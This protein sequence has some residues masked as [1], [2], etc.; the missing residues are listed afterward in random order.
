MVHSFNTYLSWGSNMPDTVLSK[1]WKWFINQLSL[2]EFALL[3]KLLWC[4]LQLTLCFPACKEEYKCTDLVKRFAKIQIQHPIRL[5]VSFKNNMKLIGLD[6]F[7]FFF[8]FLAWLILALNRA[9]SQGSWLPFL[10]IHSPS[11]SSLLCQYPCQAPGAPASGI[12][13]S[14]C[15]RNP[16][17]AP[18]TPQW[19]L[20]ALIPPRLLR[21]FCNHI[22]S[23]FL[24]T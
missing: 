9:G 19:S 8:F 16:R 23:I 21:K 6:L 24:V 5:V 2:D 22:L 13:V 3:P 1:R 18:S 10:N 11:A 17:H 14:S 12:H 15:S 20:Q 4:Y 7:F